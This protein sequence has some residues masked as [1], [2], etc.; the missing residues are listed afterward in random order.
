MWYSRI[1]KF[2]LEYGIIKY[3]FSFTNRF[4]SSYAFMSNYIQSVAKNYAPSLVDDP[5]IR[6]FM[7]T[8]FQVYEKG[9]DSLLP[10]FLMFYNNLKYVDTYIK[11]VSAARYDNFNNVRIK[12]RQS[13]DKCIYENYYG[14]SKSIYL[15]FFA[16]HNCY[17]IYGASSS[18]LS[19]TLNPLIDKL[20]SD[21]YNFAAKILQC[22]NAN[23]DTTKNCVKAAVSGIFQ[24]I[25]LEN[26]IF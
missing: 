1:Y 8:S 13:L 10:V 5:E 11:Y 18:S 23:P 14:F 4:R 15:G 16:M 6:D 22:A 24:H 2:N 19:S 17:Q 12:Y 20:D 25:F 26:I 3:L 9:V 7:N 21:V